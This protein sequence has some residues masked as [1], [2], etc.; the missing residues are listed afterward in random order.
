MD[1]ALSAH[2][3]PALHAAATHLRTVDM[4][5]TLWC[6][7][8]YVRRSQSYSSYASRISQSPLSAWGFWSRGRYAA[9]NAAG[10]GHK[11]AITQ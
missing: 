10:R 1:T 11:M 4:A 7:F 5:K 3:T 9:Y 2:L 6:S 8:M